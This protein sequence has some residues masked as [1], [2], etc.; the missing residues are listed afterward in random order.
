MQVP[1]PVRP[2]QAAPVSASGLPET[3]GQDAGEAPITCDGAHN[4]VATADVAFA[5]GQIVVAGHDQVLRLILR[6]ERTLNAVDRI[7]LAVVV[8]STPEGMA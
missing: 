2:V 6:A 7:G 5:E 3:Y 1:C 8:A 4:R